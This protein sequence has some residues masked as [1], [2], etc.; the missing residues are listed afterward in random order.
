M[1]GCPPPF[2]HI[3]DKTAISLRR[4]EIASSDDS[5]AGRS[6][7][8]ATRSPRRLAEWAVQ[9][10]PLPSGTVSSSRSISTLSE[11]GAT[12]S[13]G[14]SPSR[15]ACA[16]SLSDDAL[17]ALGF[18]ASEPSTRLPALLVEPIDVPAVEP[19]VVVGVE[20]RGLTGAA[21]G[22]AGGPPAAPRGAAS[23]VPAAGG[24]AADFA[25][26]NRPIQPGFSDLG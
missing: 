19:L 22:A 12:S 10:S 25:L 11:H 14:G 13:C 23:T 6:I 20:G 7:L 26:A 21:A 18:P 5:R 3:W 4:S 2:W 17:S 9:N 24:A 1:F 15:T 8:S 16:R